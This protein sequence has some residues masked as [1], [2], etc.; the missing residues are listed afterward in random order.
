MNQRGLNRL[1]AAVVL[2]VV[3]GCQG[4][5]HHEGEQRLTFMGSYGEPVSDGVAWKA[6]KGTGQNAA[7]TVGYDYFVKDRLALMVNGTPYRI[8]NQSDG[9]VYAGEFQ[10]GLRYYICDFDVFDRPMAFYAEALG[11]IMQGRRSV[12]ETGHTFNF[13]Q[14]TGV[15]F[16]WRIGENVSWISGYRVKHLSDGDFFDDENP[17]QNDQF[18]YTGLAIS[19]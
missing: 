2:P 7:L 6:G 3:M 13:T 14:D 1:A 15:G 11:G 9:D 17:A 8:Y 10:I 18:V 19:W 4:G 5:L 16:E 12:P